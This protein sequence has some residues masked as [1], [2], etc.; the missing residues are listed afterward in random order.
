MVLWQLETKSLSCL[1]YRKGI[2]VFKITQR[3]PEHSSFMR[4]KRTHANSFRLVM[5]SHEKFFTRQ[6]SCNNKIAALWVWQM[7]SA[8]TGLLLSY[9]CLC[10]KMKKHWRFSVHLR[11]VKGKV[12]HICWETCYITITCCNFQVLFGTMF[13]SHGFWKS[14]FNATTLFSGQLEILKCNLRKSLL[15]PSLASGCW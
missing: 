10:S 13:F 14:G 5:L 9:V 11:L 8:T 1:R 6:W 4:P 2:A 3:G 12:E 7:P 15:A